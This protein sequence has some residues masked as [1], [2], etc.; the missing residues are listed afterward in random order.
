M[1]YSVSCFVLSCFVALGCQTAPYP[2]VSPVSVSAISPGPSEQRVADQLIIV[3]DVSGTM[4]A[5]GTFPTAKAI[6]QALVAAL[7]AGDARSDRPSPW[8][9]GSIGFGGGDRIVQ[10][11]GAF[12]RAALAANAAAL[13]PLGS[14]DGR[15]GE[16]PYR[17]VFGEVAAALE[18]RSGHAAVVLISDGRPDQAG[19]A[20]AAAQA[21]VA[22]YREKICIHTVHTGDDAA[23]AAYLKSLSALSGGCGSATNAAALASAEG[24]Q[25]F[26]RSVMLGAGPVARG[27]APDPC[28]EVIR[29]RGVQ[30]AFD[31]ADVA[32]DSRVVL[33]VAAEQLGRCPGVR[34]RV[35]GHTDF[36]G[37]DAYNQRLSERRAAAVR[38]YLSSR[39]VDGTRLESRGFGE[40]RPIAPGKSD[41]DRALNRRVELHPLE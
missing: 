14:I 23:G 6:T 41:A 37:A 10:P 12:D 30:F 24:L 15:G 29:L 2:A 34:V 17:H 36:V 27:V 31:K 5:A 11:L 18:G 26:A 28:N 32:P 7:P 35:E 20:T 21:L 9:A 1:R 38:D 4:A 13:V 16:T 40:S 25:S 39:G 3:T 22:G 8:E 33:D 19:A